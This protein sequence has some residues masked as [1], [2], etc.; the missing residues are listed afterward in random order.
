[1]KKMCPVCKKFVEETFTV[2]NNNLEPFTSINP[3]EGLVAWGGYGVARTVLCQYANSVHFKFDHDGGEHLVFMKKYDADKIQAIRDHHEDHP[4]PCDHEDCT[5][6]G[7]PCYL[8]WEMEEPEG[9][10]CA[11]HDVDEGYCGSCHTF[12]SGTEGF[13]FEHPGLCAACHAMFE[14][15]FGDEGEDDDWSDYD[16]DDYYPTSFDIIE[17]EE[18]GVDIS[19]DN[20]TMGGQPS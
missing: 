1:M 2:H 19:P 4:Q 5:N 12:A 10:F 16:Y 17:R 8:P 14:S 7:A 3:M 20:P 15:E 18:T 11:E 13:D 9:Y 6:E